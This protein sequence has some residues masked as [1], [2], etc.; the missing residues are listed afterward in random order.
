MKPKTTEIRL[1]QE[2]IGAACAISQ[3]QASRSLRAAGIEP[4]AD[5]YALADLAR[6]VEFRVLERVGATA[7]G[8]RFDVDAERGRLL[9]AQASLAELKLATEKRDLVSAADVEFHWKDMI[10]CMR[11]K[12][13]QLPSRITLVCAHTHETRV[14]MQALAEGLVREALEEVARG[15]MPPTDDAK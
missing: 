3:G 14:K 12:L 15:A 1:T 2:Q 4:G 9:A 8:R 11:G 7:D 5:G 10:L 13:L 6:L